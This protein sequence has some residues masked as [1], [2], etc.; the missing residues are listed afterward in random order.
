MNPTSINPP[1]YVRNFCEKYSI[2]LAGVQ[3]KM[4]V[5]SYA[6]NVP[7]AITSE[8]EIA[9]LRVSMG[10]LFDHERQIMRRRLLLQKLA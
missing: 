6:N 1:T 4:L 3:S 5:F 7:S 9:N 10:D 2:Y 8:E